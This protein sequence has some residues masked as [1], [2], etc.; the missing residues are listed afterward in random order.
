M[1]LVVEISEEG[2]KLD[3]L[4]TNIGEQFQ[5]IYDTYTV[6]LE[7]GSAL[8]TITYKTWF[9]HLTLRR[10]LIFDRAIQSIC[11]A[12]VQT[13]VNCVKPYHKKGQIM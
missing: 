9:L 3:K 7:Y 8:S 12:L 13:D 10:D 2:Q 11:S 4:I 6:I 5:E 1:I